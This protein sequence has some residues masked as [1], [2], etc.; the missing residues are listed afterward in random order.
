M[1][2]R[3][4]PRKERQKI[5]LVTPWFGRELTGGAELHAWN[6]ACRL[7]ERGFKLEILTTCCKAYSEDWA[8]NHLKPGLTEEKEGFSIRR[9]RVS[10]RDKS[11]FDRVC[12][13]LHNTDR[14]HLKPG[15]SPLSAEEETVFSDELIR[16]DYLFEFLATKSGNYDAF[17]FLPYLYGPILKGLPMVA[18]KSILLPCLHDE[19]YAYLDITQNIFYKAKSI[20]WLS[21]G[22]Y[23]LGLKLYGPG[24]VH[25]STVAGAGVEID[26]FTSDTTEIPNE[27]NSND[28][29]ILT[30]GRKD[31]GKG[32]HFLVDAFSDFKKRS[33]SRLKLV[34][35]GPGKD[36][37]NDSSNGIVDFGFVSNELRHW[38]L[39]NCVALAQP[40]R[41]ESFAR[42][43]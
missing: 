27:L 18:T 21:E 34:I 35:A 13:K 43:L 25:K 3:S 10:K 42:D 2:T 8:T 12:S 16:S 1:K 17:L 9:F 7:A 11:Q 39:R 22:E 33:Q 24:I 29:F 40:S 14:K 31:K 30:L 26:R 23:E 37:L 41:N 15:V 38:L 32:V 28:S 20:L 19:S 4:L 5:A 6:V 36:D